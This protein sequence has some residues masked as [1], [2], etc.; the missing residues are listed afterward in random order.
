MERS[1]LRSRVT[2]AGRY[3]EGARRLA[4]RT[5][6]LCTVASPLTRM[7]RA[8]AVWM[9]DTWT[10][11]LLAAGRGAQGTGRVGATTGDHSAGVPHLA[12]AINQGLREEVHMTNSSKT[13]SLYGK[14]VDPPIVTT[15]ALATPWP[16]LRAGRFDKD[17]PPGRPRRGALLIRNGKGSLWC[18]FQRFA[19]VRRFLRTSGTVAA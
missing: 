11:G 13:Q 18:F 8:A 16:P 19:A 15:G 9:T 17:R 14:S 10:A 5:P 6:T 12:G 2:T 7:T 1:S 4:C 3:A